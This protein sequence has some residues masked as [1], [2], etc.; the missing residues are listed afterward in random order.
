MNKVED[1]IKTVFNKFHNTV[2]SIDGVFFDAL[3]GFEL[4]LREINK[5]QQEYI[6]QLNSPESEEMQ[7]QQLDSAWMMY[8]EDNPNESNAITHHIVTQREFKIRNSEDGSN[9]IFIGNMGLIAIYQYWD[10]HCRKRV[11][12]VLGVEKD[13]IHCDVFGDMRIIR[14]SIIHNNGIALPDI[15]GCKVLDWFKQG[16]SIVIDKIKFLGLLKHLK[17]LKIESPKTP[18]RRV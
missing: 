5:H 8:G 11:A 10:D 6:R 2:N 7:H 9:Y 1:Q 17:H 18:N 15:I 12:A 14:H 4:N 13:Q 16:D 3:Q